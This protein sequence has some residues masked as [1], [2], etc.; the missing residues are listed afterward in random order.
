VIENPFEPNPDDADVERLLTAF[1]AARLEPSPRGAERTRAAVMAAARSRRAA[2]GGGLFGRGGRLAAA[3]LLAA[4]LTVAFGG[5]ALAAGPGS[6][7]YGLRLWVETVTL[8]SEANARA[9][10]QLA[11]LDQRLSEARAAS[12]GQD[13]NAVAAA[14]AAYRQEIVDLLATADGDEAR[15]AKLEAALGTHLVALRTLSSKVPEQARD[16]IQN[17]IENSSKAVDKVH[18]S[19]GKP[20]ASPGPATSPGPGRTPQ[21]HPSGGPPSDHPGGNQP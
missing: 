14:L 19:Q 6:P 18:E 7:L 9:D 16:A 8:P 12:Q 17:A 11:L 13:A 15:L 2:T 20:N 5:A 1:A 4:S 3:A 21:P 10:A